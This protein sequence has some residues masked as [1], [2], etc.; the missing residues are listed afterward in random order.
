MA[1]DDRSAPT[2]YVDLAAY[3]RPELLELIGELTVMFGRLEYMV[4]LA[5]KRK[6]GLSLARAQKLYKHYSLGAKVFGKQSCAQAGSSCRDFDSR[7]V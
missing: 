1:E 4:L 5:L 2:R 6:S 3:T 7:R